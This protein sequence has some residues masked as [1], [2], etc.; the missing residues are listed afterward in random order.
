VADALCLDSDVGRIVSAEKKELETEIATDLSENT[1]DNEPY[2]AYKLLTRV[3]KSVRTWRMECKQAR[4]KVETAE[5]VV[6]LRDG[7]MA[8]LTESN[9]KLIGEIGYRER[10]VAS[11]TERVRQL[12]AAL[13]A[14]QKEQPTPPPP[15]EP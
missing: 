10:D 3:A 11:L 13:A 14:A 2:T 15:A 6:R 7:E 8:R 1:I 4:D 9:S 12:E 5:Q